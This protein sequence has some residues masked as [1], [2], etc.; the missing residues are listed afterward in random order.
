MTNRKSNEDSKIEENPINEYEFKGTGLTTSE[1]RLAKQRFEEY[2]AHYHVEHISDLSLLEELCFREALQERTKKAIKKIAKSKTVKDQNLVPKHL[3]SAL[4]ENLERILTLKK[5]L[6]LFEDKKAN[7]PF[8]YIQTLKKKF[9]IWMDENQGS[10]TLICPHCS[11]MVLLKIRTEAWQAQK[12]PFFQDRILANK[13][14]WKLYREGKITKEDVSKVLGVSSDYVIWM[15][16][17]IPQEP[18]K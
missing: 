10:R 3:L 18:S 12:H 6:G 15:G 14:L 9:K 7:D 2:K 16:E 1:R 13:H 5:E 11:K 4:D 8:K 17:K